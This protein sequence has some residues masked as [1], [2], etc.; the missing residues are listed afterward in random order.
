MCQTNLLGIVDELEGSDALSLE[1]CQSKCVSDM[2]KCALARRLFIQTR[3]L[4]VRCARV[5]CWSIKMRFRHAQM[6]S[7]STLFFPN[8]SP[9]RSGALS[10]D[11]RQSA[12]LLS[13]CLNRL[14]LR[15]KTPSISPPLRP[16]RTDFVSLGKTRYSSV[17]ML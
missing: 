17:E 6:L 2:L 15:S 3:F 9:M 12:D 16:P 8:P 14:Y 1:A 11:E 4:M 7:R 5:Q 10:L 13:V